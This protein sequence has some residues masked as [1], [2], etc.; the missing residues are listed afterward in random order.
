MGAVVPLMKLAFILAVMGVFAVGYMAL[1][2]YVAQRIARDQLRRE[3][4]GAVWMLK[5]MEIEDNELEKIRYA[6]CRAS[7]WQLRP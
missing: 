2:R 4:E 3:L 7:N 6:M 1:L 5:G